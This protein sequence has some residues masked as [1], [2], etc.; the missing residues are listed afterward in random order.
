MIDEPDSQ[1]VHRYS[2]TLLMLAIA[3]LSTKLGNRR[4]NPTHER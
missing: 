1:S 2:A 3:S 4:I